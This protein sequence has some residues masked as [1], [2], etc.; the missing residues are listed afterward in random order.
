MINTFVCLLHYPFL[1]YPHNLTLTFHIFIYYLQ[2][3]VYLFSFSLHNSKYTTNHNKQTVDFHYGLHWQNE[4]TASKGQFLRTDMLSILHCIS[5]NWTLFN[6]QCAAQTT[7]QT[8]LRPCINSIHT[9]SPNLSL[10][11]A[12]ALPELAADEFCSVS[13]SGPNRTTEQH[14][15]LFSSLYFSFESVVQEYALFFLNKILP[16]AVN[17]KHRRKGRKLS[18]ERKERR[19]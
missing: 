7:K 5:P 10:K 12:A 14:R 13:L 3:L 15:A 16:N 19:R 2:F 9:H 11:I 17:S 4:I 1:M 8:T 18:I 6:S